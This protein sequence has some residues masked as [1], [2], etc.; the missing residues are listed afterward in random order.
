MFKL[1]AAIVLQGR[2]LFPGSREFRTRRIGFNL[3]VKAG[4]HVDMAE[5]ATLRYVA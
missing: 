5:A 4:E 1:V 3:F 2:F